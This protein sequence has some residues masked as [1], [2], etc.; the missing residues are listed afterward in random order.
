MPVIP[1]TQRESRGRSKDVVSQKPLPRVYLDEGPKTFKKYLKRQ[2]KQRERLLRSFE[3]PYTKISQYQGTKILF[4]MIML[5]SIIALIFYYN[6]IPQY[7]YLS[8]NGIVYQFTYY[9]IFT[10]LFVSSGDIL[11]LFFLFI[12]LYILYFMARNIEK[13][14][15][16]KFLI[17]IYLIGCLFSAIFY[18]LLRVLFIFYLPLDYAVLVGLAWGGILSL[19][20]YSIFPIMNQQITALMYFLPIRMKGRSFLIMIILFRLIPALL[21]ALYEPI[22]IVFYLPELGGVL[23]AYII[24]KYKFRKP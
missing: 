14:Y 17:K 5:F 3:K 1:T 4:I 24:Y 11:S 21:Y 9:T 23:G 8:L 2:D 7:I 12:M 18:V 15:G 20:S 22:Y 6:E 19:I 13:S 10:S 16:T